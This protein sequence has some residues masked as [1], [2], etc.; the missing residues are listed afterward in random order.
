MLTRGCAGG[1]R[2]SKEPK[3]N[4]QGAGEPGRFPNDDLGGSDEEGDGDEDDLS[5]SP[6]GMIASSPDKG[7]CLR[8]DAAVVE[9]TKKDLKKSRKRSKKKKKKSAGSTTKQSCPPRVVLSSLFPSGEY[10]EGE[11]HPYSENLARTTGEE[12]RANDRMD[13]TFLSDYRQAAEA[14]RQV[15]K[16]AQSVIKPGKGL[17]EIAEGIEDGV[18]A[19]IDHQGVKTGDSLRAGMGFPT[20]L[21][22]NN[23]AAH[24]T[25]T[26]GMKD[27]EL[28]SDDVLKVDFGVH[29]NG[30]IVDSAFTVAFDP[31]YDNLLASVKD[32]TNTG[33]QVSYPRP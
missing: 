16:W 18:R 10:P 15:R 21:C 19:L 33:I 12:H 1:N 27:V 9:L 22:L 32:A 5:K 11:V 25:P 26:P 17:T 23:T 8:A 28:K 14:H 30:R 24:Y 20:G 29:V 4:I 31:M 2:I 13:S 6:T 7:T 3:S